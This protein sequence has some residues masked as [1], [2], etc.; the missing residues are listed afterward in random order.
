[1]LIV[2]FGEISCIYPCLTDQIRLLVRVWVKSGKIGLKMWLI[3]RCMM[4]VWELHTSS[5]GMQPPVGLHFKPNICFSEGR[6]LIYKHTK[7]ILGNCRTVEGGKGRGDM[8]TSENIKYLLYHIPLWI[9]IKNKT[10]QTFT[11]DMPI[12]HYLQYLRNN[13]FTSL[14]LRFWTSFLAYTANI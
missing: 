3:Y 8:Y 4:G 11:S 6:H 7:L 10:Y 9:F 5:D 12:I 2:F 13:S 1:M 14:C